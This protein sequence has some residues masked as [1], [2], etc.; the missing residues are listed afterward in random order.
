VFVCVCLS[1]FEFV[2]V[3]VCACLCLCLFVFVCVVLVCVLCVVCILLCLL[4]L[5]VRN[6]LVLIIWPEI[7]N[8]RTKLKG[9]ELRTIVIVGL[10][11]F[12]NKKRK[13][14]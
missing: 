4:C 2:F 13:E 14:K 5:C 12:E 6:S 3:C 9:T 11:K 8:C 7:T 10:K 1:L